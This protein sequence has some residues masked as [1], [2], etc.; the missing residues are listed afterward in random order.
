MG[1]DEWVR[2]SLHLHEEQRNVETPRL[3][4]DE[5]RSEAKMVACNVGLNAEMQQPLD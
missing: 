5:E 4:S 1:L 2:G 3:A